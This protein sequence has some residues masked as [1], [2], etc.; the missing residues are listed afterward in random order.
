[1]IRYEIASTAILIE[2]FFA[3]FVQGETL[4]F[5]LQITLTEEC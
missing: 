1:M 5:T 4:P 2:I 3:S